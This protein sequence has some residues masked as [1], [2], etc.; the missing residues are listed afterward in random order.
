MID[1]DRSDQIVNE[2]GPITSQSLTR[3]YEQ[4]KL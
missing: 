2:R 3:Q 1:L 4:L